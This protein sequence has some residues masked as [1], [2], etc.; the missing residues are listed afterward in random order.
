MARRGEHSREEIRQMALDAAETIVAR[1]G[2]PGLSTRKVA[3]AIRYTVGTLYLVFENL[4][5][6]TLQVNA[7][8]LDALYEWLRAR[9]D[10]GNDPEQAI[11]ALANAYVAYAEAETPR[12]SMLFEYAVQ[13]NAQPEWYLNKLGRV[14]GLVEAALAP[15]SADALETQRIARVL[16]ASVHGICLLKIRQRLTLAGNQDAEAM[17]RMLV[18]HFLRGLR[19]GQKFSPPN[20]V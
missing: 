17:T 16:W 6:L 2:Y 3:S 14:F 1:E 20:P 7:R 8:T 5:D 15:L 18:S 4:D 10:K 19:Q 13:E 9:Q 11:F 12:W